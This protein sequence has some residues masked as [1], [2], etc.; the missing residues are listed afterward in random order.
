VEAGKKAATG[1]LELQKGIL[2][3]LDRAGK[4]LGVPELATALKAKDKQPLIFY[5][6]RHLSQTGRIKRLGHGPGSTFRALTED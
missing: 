3:Q 5:L 1:S 4:P 2:R 6:C